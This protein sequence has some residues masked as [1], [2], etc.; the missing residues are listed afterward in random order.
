MVERAQPEAGLRHLDVLRGF[1]SADVPGLVR[2]YEAAPGVGAAL[3]EF[4][5]PGVV[6]A[7]ATG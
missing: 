7:A 1:L 3:V 6:G 2:C 5:V 4:E